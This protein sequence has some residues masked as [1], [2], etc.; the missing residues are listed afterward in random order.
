MRIKKKLAKP[1]IAVLVASQCVTAFGGSWV[2]S[3]AEV[4]RYQNDDGTFLQNGWFLDPA[5]GKWYYLDEQGVM[6]YGWKYIDNVWYFFNPVH[7]GTFGS[8]A[9]NG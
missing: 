4:W 7:D 3:S 8:M 9:A 6:T 2:N 5:D 1:L